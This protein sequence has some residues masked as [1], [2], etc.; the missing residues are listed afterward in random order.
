MNIDDKIVVI[1]FAVL[2]F[3]LLVWLLL[4]PIVKDIHRQEI[5]VKDVKFYK[6]EVKHDTGEI[7]THWIRPKLSYNTK[8]SMAYFIYEDPNLDSAFCMPVV[9]YDPDS[10]TAEIGSVLHFHRIVKW[11]KDEYIIGH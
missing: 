8:G 4:W 1:I 11:H 9:I 3:I 5:K 10:N 7:K 2:G 6:V